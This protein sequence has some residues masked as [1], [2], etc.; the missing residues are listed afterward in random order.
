MPTSEVVHIAYY[1]QTLVY[2]PCWDLQQ[3][4]NAGYNKFKPICSGMKWTSLPNTNSIL[5]FLHSHKK[6][7]LIFSLSTSHSSKCTNVG[8]HQ[9][10]FLISSPPCQMILFLSPLCRPVLSRFTLF[11][12]FFSLETKTNYI[13]KFI[14]TLLKTHIKMRWHVSCPTKIWCLIFLVYY[15]FVCDTGLPYTCTCM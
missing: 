5:V 4:I 12:P 13:S 1:K 3:I 15:E 10:H 9:C 6:H 11:P 14:F 8:L 7:T 2:I